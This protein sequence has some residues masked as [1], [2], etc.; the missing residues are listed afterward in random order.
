MG[1]C[2]VGADR[3]DIYEEGPCTYQCYNH[4]LI[5]DAAQSLAPLQGNMCRSYQYVSAYK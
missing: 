1:T 5:A 4:I 2:Y 3:K